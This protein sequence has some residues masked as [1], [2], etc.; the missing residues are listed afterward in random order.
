[1]ACLLAP[2]AAVLIVNR[3]ESKDK[4]M[5]RLL[6]NV[7]SVGWPFLQMGGKIFFLLLGFFWISQHDVVL[8]FFLTNSSNYHTYQ[9][10][11]NHSI[12][13]YINNNI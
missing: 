2:V 7:I 3:R 11:N 9:Y 4:I 12:T 6:L 5:V 13:I 8:L 10:K 1:M